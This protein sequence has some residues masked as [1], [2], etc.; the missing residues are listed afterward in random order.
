MHGACHYTRQTLPGLNLKTASW[1][2]FDEGSMRTTGGQNA[3]RSGKEV[4]P[5]SKAIRGG[6]VPGGAGG[7]GT[8]VELETW[9][10]AQRALHRSRNQGMRP[11]YQPRPTGLGAGPQHFGE[12]FLHAK[13]QPPMLGEPQSLLGPALRTAVP[14]PA[15]DAWH[16]AEHVNK[17]DE[18]GVIGIDPASRSAGEAFATLSDLKGVRPGFEDAALMRIAVSGRLSRGSQA[19]FE[20][21]I[22][23]A[24]FDANRPAIGGAIFMRGQAQDLE[25]CA[26]I[27]EHQLRY[28]MQI[29]RELVQF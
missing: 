24:V 2:L 20:A 19:G 5:H 13:R 27:A 12:K 15:E 10:V 25:R 28:F 22:G 9:L 7:S 14:L 4:D 6:A 3:E 17:P 21:E 26:R 11:A 8:P 18:P 29:D 23:D 16:L 1:A